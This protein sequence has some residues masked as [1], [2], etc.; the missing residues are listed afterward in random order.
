[1]RNW[2]ML[3]VV[4]VLASLV[5]C[6]TYQSERPPVD[7]LDKRDRGLQS[8]DVVDASERMA[9]ELLGLAEL[10]QPTRQ[11]V[12]VTNV[13]N[14]TSN[15]YW[16]YDIFL[17]RLKGVIARNGRDR[18]ALIGNRENVQNLRNSEL[19]GGADDFG[20]GGGQRPVQGSIQ[21]EWALQGTV[22]DLPNRGTN[23]YY[24]DFALTNIRTRE[25]IPVA[26]EVR[27]AR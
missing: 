14:K 19:E 12:V 22:S 15:P 24:F 25:T 10:N 2:T 9:Q 3:V 5:G 1:M 4:A 16:N 23:Y 8:K 21:P 17:R 7:Q 18:I 26:F 20:Q 27:V 13:E 11:T 6:R